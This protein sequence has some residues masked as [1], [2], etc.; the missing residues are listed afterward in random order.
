MNGFWGGR[1]ECAFVNVRV[2]NPFAPSNTTSSLSTC[3]K[4]HENIK[5]RA[6]GQRIREV[7]HASFTPVVMS[8]TGGL[9]HEAT[10]FY[11]RLASLLAHKWGDDY[12]IVMG[13]LR[14]MLLVVFLIAFCHPMYPWCPLLYWALC[15]GSST[16]GSG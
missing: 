9:G 12:S 8:A 3:Y 13:W 2:F 7:E 6:Y 14:C 4:K 5:K 16:D 10:F 15:F 1:S 11:K